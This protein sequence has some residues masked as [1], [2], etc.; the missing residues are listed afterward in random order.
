MGKRSMY[1]HFVNNR[2]HDHIKTARKIQTDYPEAAAFYAAYVR[3]IT[4]LDQTKVAA[5]LTRH[6]DIKDR[7]T[8]ALE[9]AVFNKTASVHD[10]VRDSYIGQEL[11]RGAYKK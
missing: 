9:D 6:S 8:G 3:D 4:N 2:E 1:P 11:L 10:V 5:I 7:V